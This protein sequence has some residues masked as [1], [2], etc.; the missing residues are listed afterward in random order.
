LSASVHA[1]ILQFVCLSILPPAHH[2]AQVFVC[3][4]V[5]FSICPFLSEE[6]TSLNLKGE[7]SRSS[8]YY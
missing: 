5:R 2:K 8:L 6:M 4:S 7:R 3:P 1:F